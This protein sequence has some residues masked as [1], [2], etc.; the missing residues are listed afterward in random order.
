ME[1]VC[2]CVCVCTLLLVST[3]QWQSEDS[4]WELAL[5]LHPPGKCFYLRK[6]IEPAPMCEAG[7]I[8]S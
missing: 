8:G 4:F 2:V 3:V 5:S 6:N 7:L 1:C